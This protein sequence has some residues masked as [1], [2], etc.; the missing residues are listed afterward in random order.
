MQAMHREPG[1]LGHRFIKI[2]DFVNVAEAKSFD[3][4][5]LKHSAQNIMNAQNESKGT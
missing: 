3:L 2:G 1:E 5:I 4:G